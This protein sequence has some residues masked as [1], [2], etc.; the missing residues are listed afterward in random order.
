[1]AVLFSRSLRALDSKQLKAGPASH[2]LLGLLALAWCVWFFC[3]RVRVT[4]SASAGRI[5]AAETGHPIQSAVR[6]YVVAIHEQLGQTVTQGD[7]LVE[8]DAATEE[9][10]LARSL[11]EQHALE[12]QRDALQAE[13]EL[14]AQAVVTQRQASLVHVAEADARSSQADGLLRFREDER[15]RSVSL[16]NA[17]VLS[18]LELSRRVIDAE[19]QRA[20]VSAMGLAARRIRADQSVTDAERVERLAALRHELTVVAGNLTTITTRIVEDEHEVDKR[21]IRSPVR[22]RLG[23]VLPTTVGAFVRE[24]EALGTVVPEGELHIVASFAPDEALGRIHPGQ[25]GRMRLTG[26]PWMQYGT[27]SGTVVHVAEE[28]RDGLV[29]VELSIAKRAPRPIPVQHGL[30][31]TVEIE[32]ERASPATLVWRAAGGQFDAIHATP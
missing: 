31:G 8:L 23:E 10:A 21:R 13:A 26:F 16:Q 4:A 11:A 32:I 18:E 25:S 12:Q 5:E 9:H 3:A 27:V 28:L 7:V 22:G 6:G 30:Q 19:Q 2:A 17:G 24:G 1:M 14:A 29:R 20:E 15:A